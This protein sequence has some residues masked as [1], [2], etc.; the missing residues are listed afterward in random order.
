MRGL[1][2]ISESSRIYDRYRYCACCVNTIITVPVITQHCLLFSESRRLF[3]HNLHIIV[4]FIKSLT[5]LRQAVHLNIRPYD[6]HGNWRKYEWIPFQEIDIVSVFYTEI[7]PSYM[8]GLWSDVAQNEQVLLCRNLNWIFY[9]LFIIFITHNILM[10][11]SFQGTSAS[12]VS[13]RFRSTQRDKGEST[14]VTGVKPV[15]DNAKHNSS[16][17][18]YTHFP[19]YNGSPFSDS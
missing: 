10:F 17:E 3:A 11:F 15:W 14:L 4:W 2:C 6:L 18:W 12:M 5:F 1:L 9:V 7:L 8:N 19:V 13:T 16:D